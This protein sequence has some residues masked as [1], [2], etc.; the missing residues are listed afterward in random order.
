MSSLKVATVA[1]LV[2]AAAAGAV[3]DPGS[4]DCAR[5]R[6][7]GLSPGMTAREVR[8]RMEDR[9]TLGA[10]RRSVEY[11]QSST[12]IH[13]E[14]DDDVGRK[15]ATLVLV[16]S[17]IPASVDS[18]PVLR[19]LRWRLGEPTTGVESLDD[20]LQRG[21]AAWVSEPCG[22]VVQAV[23]EG[24]HLWD[25]ARAGIYIEARPLPLNADRL[26]VERTPGDSV[27]DRLL[28][29]PALGA[30]APQVER[31]GPVPS[32]VA[33]PETLASDAAGD[34]ASGT[35]TEP[36]VPPVEEAAAEPQ[37]VPAAGVMAEE[38]V[39]GAV[40]TDPE[41]LARYYV[42]PVFPAAARMARTSGVVHLRVVVRQ[43]GR[44]G[45]AEVVECSR[46]GVGFEESAV[47]AVKRWR[48]RPATFA[49]RPVSTSITVKIDF[50]E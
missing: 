27:V 24:E 39:A 29:V 49:G 22:I 32:A 38:G 10:D 8:D 12:Q 25:P 30:T 17:H 36:S 18:A 26:V 45:E 2:L 21:P 28:E 46:P 11:S 20:D 35:D 13:V 15:T 33:P 47:E 41:R 19:S 40:G 3:A 50:T 23:R 16:R 14:Y 9:G 6:L 31:G 5:Y 44:V 37:L 7:Y 43:D 48:Y 4:P 42:K 1:A 34:A